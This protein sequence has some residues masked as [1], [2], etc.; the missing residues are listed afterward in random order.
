MNAMIWILLQLLNQIEADVIVNIIYKLLAYKHF[1][2]EI[3]R[4]GWTENIG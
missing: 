1:Y 4:G 2:M 3:I